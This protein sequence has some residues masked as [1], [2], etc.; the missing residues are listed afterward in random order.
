MATQKKI[1]K[2]A[3]TI[4]RWIGSPASL[5][6]HTILFAAS[7]VAVDVGLIEWSAMLLFVTTL[8]S[9]EAIYLSIFIQMSINYTTQEL[10]DV[11][12]DID[13]IQ[14]D[15]DELQED[16]EDIT[17]DFEE[18]TEEEKTDALRKLEQK[19]ALGSIQADLRRLMADIER[20]KSSPSTGPA[21]SDK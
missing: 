3:L 1:E 2:T 10:E 21:K 17:E 8:V 5:V 19:M 18:M 20:L 16:V 6:V 9:L 15:I 13:E 14:K 12:E 4:T 7:F 11:G